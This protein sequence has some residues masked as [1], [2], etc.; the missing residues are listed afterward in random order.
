M[1]NT[2]GALQD[3]LDALNDLNIQGSMFYNILRLQLI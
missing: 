2:E 1:C 3:A